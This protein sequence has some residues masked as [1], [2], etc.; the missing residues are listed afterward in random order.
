[1]TDSPL[2][3]WVVGQ[4]QDVLEQLGAVSLCQA[5]LPKVVAR[6]MRETKK[7]R[8]FRLFRLAVML[9]NSPCRES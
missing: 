8:P 5:I 7:T 9:L 3:L 1:M 4:I 2:E 6:E